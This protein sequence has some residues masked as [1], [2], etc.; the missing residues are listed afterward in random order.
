VKYFLIK[1]KGTLITAL[2]FILLLCF[3]YFRDTERN[4]ADLT[5]QTYDFIGVGEEVSS[6][7]IYYPKSWIL[8]ESDGEGW[9]LLRDEEKLNADNKVIDRLVED[10]KL[11]LIHI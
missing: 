1:F 4:S 5:P 2:V 6:V 11:S 3:I 8:L 9:F 10:I 7:E